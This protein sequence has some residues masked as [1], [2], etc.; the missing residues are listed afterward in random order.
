MFG[1][2]PLRS[3]GGVG[4]LIESEKKGGVEPPSSSSLGTPSLQSLKQSTETP[5]VTSLCTL[6][7]TTLI[8]WFPHLR[9]DTQGV[10]S[11]TRRTISH[12][13]VPECPLYQTRREE[14]H[15]R[16][17]IFMFVSLVQETRRGSESPRSRI[18]R[19]HRYRL[20]NNQQRPSRWVDV[21]P[22]FDPPGRISLRPRP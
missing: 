15:R 20:T 10:R 13:R 6:V 4:T 8:S 21:T 2:E 7:P 22:R 5:E 12:P 3:D 19:R 16:H 9:C 17:T 18:S 1:V 11:P 14:C